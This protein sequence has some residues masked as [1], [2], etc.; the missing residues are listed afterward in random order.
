MK[1]MSIAS[2]CFLKVFSRRWVG[3]SMGSTRVGTKKCLGISLTRLRRSRSGCLCWWRQGCKTGRSTKVRTRSGN[4]FV[5]KGQIRSG[6][7]SHIDALEGR[8]H[9]AASVKR[10]RVEEAQALIFKKA[11]VSSHLDWSTNSLGNALIWMRAVIK[12]MPH[13]PLC[14]S[15]PWA[16][17]PWLGCSSGWWRSSS[18][19]LRFWRR[20]L[21]GCL[22]N[23]LLLHCVLHACAVQNRNIASPIKGIV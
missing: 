4:R 1:S 20:G 23:R 3:R 22:Y 2:L 9:H 16:S 8:R 15:Q 18:W 7:K 5:Q 17:K 14:L 11:R 19:S 12:K 6:S 10:E 13:P 21:R